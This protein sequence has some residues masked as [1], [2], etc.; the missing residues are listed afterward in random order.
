[1]RF[2]SVLLGI[3]LTMFT[4][5]KFTWDKERIAKIEDKMMKIEE[6]IHDEIVYGS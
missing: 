5:A 1:M 4:D 2:S 3:T 6:I